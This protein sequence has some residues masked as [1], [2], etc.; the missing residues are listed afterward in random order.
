MDLSAR[1][2]EHPR[3]RGEVA[4]V[5]RSKP[6]SSSRRAGPGST[7]AVVRATCSGS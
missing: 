4:V 6:T 7:A 2:A 5:I 3:D 1:R